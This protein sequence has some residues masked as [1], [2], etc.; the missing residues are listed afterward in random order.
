MITFLNWIDIQKETKERERFRK[1]LRESE[2]DFLTTL[3]LIGFLLTLLLFGRI[4]V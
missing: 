4:T 3:W 1:F 2:W